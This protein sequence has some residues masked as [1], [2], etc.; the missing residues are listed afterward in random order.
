MKGLLE[1]IPR[2]LPPKYD[3][4]ALRATVLGLEAATIKTAGEEYLAEHDL[5]GQAKYTLDSGTEL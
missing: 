1:T 5:G 2:E 3:P 4:T